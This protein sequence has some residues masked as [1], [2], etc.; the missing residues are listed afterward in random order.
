MKVQDAE[1]KINLSKF[2]Y[3]LKERGL[4]DPEFIICDDFLG[5]AILKEIFPTS[6]IQ[7]MR[8]S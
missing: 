8:Y 6:Q 7:K 1:S 5:N 4:V 3:G 2:L